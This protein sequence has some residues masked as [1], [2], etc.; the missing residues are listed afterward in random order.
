M[1]VILTYAWQ[2]FIRS[3][4]YILP[5]LYKAL[6]KGNDPDRMKGAL[7][8]LWNK[9]IGSAPT[10]LTILIWLSG[11]RVCFRWS[12]SWLTTWYNVSKPLCR[13]IIS[14]G[15]SYVSFGMPT[16]REG[17]HLEYMFDCLS[18]IVYSL[19]SR[20]WLQVLLMTACYTSTKNLHISMLMY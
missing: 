14:Q 20:N 9:G 16:R 2:H 12:V 18:L 6:S 10:S 5:S 1:A 13:S 19:P 8:I 7:Y 4:R 3:T 11:S 15:V 17:T